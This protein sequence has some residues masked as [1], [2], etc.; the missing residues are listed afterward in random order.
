MEAHT[1]VKWLFE[2]FLILTVII[3]G[4]LTNIPIC[5][6]IPVDISNSISNIDPFYMFLP[7]IV[8]QKAPLFEKANRKMGIYSSLPQQ[9]LD[10]LTG[11]Q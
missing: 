9:V 7:P 8:Q 4:L 6:Q 1:G 11:S 2:T 5:S 3:I 10:A